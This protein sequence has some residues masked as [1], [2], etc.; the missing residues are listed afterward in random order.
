MKVEIYDFGVWFDGK[1][2]E[3]EVSDD[4]LARC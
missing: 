1:K 2:Y 3:A 4:F